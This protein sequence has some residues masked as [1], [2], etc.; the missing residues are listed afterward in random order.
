MNLPPDKVRLLR[1]YDNEKK[2][3]LICDQVSIV[4]NLFIFPVAKT[5]NK[6]V[7]WRL[8]SKNN[9]LVN[10]KVSGTGVIIW[11]FI[12]LISICNIKDPMC[13]FQWCFFSNIWCSFEKCVFVMQERFQVKNPPH[14]Y[15]HKLRGFLDPAVTGKVKEQQKQDVNIC[16]NWYIRRRICENIDLTINKQKCKLWWKY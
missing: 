5:S 15:I 14:T 10:L 3:E 2:W 8:Q 9:I 12:I 4:K 11:Y 1:S 6:C 13:S 16:C 7:I